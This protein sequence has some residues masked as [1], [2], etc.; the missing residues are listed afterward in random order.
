MDPK[1]PENSG[2]NE[3][4]SISLPDWLVAEM[5]V[6]AKAVGLDRSKYLAQLVRADLIQGGPLIL[7]EFPP[8]YK[9]RKEKE[10]RSVEGE[11]G[12]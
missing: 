6:R 8:D 10:A 1:S 7:R 3:T 11:S 5:D 9:T 4:C 2:K 12:V